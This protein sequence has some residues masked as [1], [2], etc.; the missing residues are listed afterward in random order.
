MSLPPLQLNPY[1][2]SDCGPSKQTSIFSTTKKNK[3]FEA[4]ANI[5]R[6]FS[7][8][9]S[10]VITIRGIETLKQTVLLELAFENILL[11]YSQY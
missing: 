10:V 9:S 1:N 7:T 8:L 3:M 6:K 11:E 4:F 2:I 5:Q